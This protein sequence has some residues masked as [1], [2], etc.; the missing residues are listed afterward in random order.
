MDL[1][2]GVVPLGPAAVAP[3]AAIVLAVALLLVV[4]MEVN[5]SSVW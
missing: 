5:L 3:D 2:T 4:G 1:D